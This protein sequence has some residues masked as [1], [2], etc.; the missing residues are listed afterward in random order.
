VSRQ[1]AE[2]G[3]AQFA[4]LLTIDPADAAEIIIDG[5]ERR[6]GRVLIGWSAKIPDL[7]ARL[8]PAA[9][10]RILTV[11]RRARIGMSSRGAHRPQLVAQAGQRA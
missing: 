9:Y 2:D 4:T 11:V 5:I 1:E 3:R 6:R 7:L 8:L 10:G